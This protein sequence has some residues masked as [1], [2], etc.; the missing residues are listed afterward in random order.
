MSTERALRFGLVAVVGFALALPWADLR[1]QARLPTQELPVLAATD[2]A[3]VLIVNTTDDTDDDTCNVVHCSLRE[4]IQAANA[5][6]VPNTVAFDIPP[7]DPG[8]NPSGWWTIRPAS[9]LPELIDDSTTIDGTTQTANRGDT[10]PLGP[11]IELDGNLVGGNGRGFY[12]RSANNVIRGLAIDRFTE[13]GIRLEGHAATNNRIVGNYLG[14]DPTGTQDRGNGWG[15]Y[16][17]LSAH[18]NTVGG[19]AREDRNLISGNDQA[20]IG[21]V[22]AGADGNRIIGN[23]IGTNAQGSEA[24]GNTYDGASIAFGAQRNV[25]GPG[26]VIAFNGRDGVRVNSSNSLSNTVTA[27]SI[28]R[29]TGKGILLIDGG[30]AKL[31]A[32]VIVTVSATTVQGMACAG[33]GVEIFSDL[34]DEGAVYEGFGTADG[35]GNWAFTKPG[36]LAG[37]NVTAT[38]TDDA[39]NTSEFSAPVAA[40]CNRVYLPLV[41]R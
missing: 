5:S 32:P 15:I 6:A 1:A 8:Y 34:E 3:A 38:A 33:C 20:G 11:E 21:L 31:V 7:S 19:A 13:T 18:D 26:N 14:T 36:G 25:I 2:E 24:L 12:I 40:L 10:N 23:F 27:N 16:I 35:A 41:R 4:A 29:N 17:Y 28:Y 39:G 9:P 22:S 30:N 37:P